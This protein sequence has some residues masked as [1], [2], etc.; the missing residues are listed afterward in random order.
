MSALVKFIV[1]I[2]VSLLFFSCQWDINLG[3]GERGNGNVV[4]EAR[5]SDESF[6][7][8]K[9]AEGLD[10]YITQDKKTSI[11][12][13]ADENIIGLIRTDIKNGILR[14]HTEERI[15]RAK[16]KKVFVS[17]PEI[18][19]LRSSSGADLYTTAVIKAD[20]IE[21]DSSSG[22]D[23]KV[24][25]EANEVDCD[26]SSGSDIVVSGKAKILYADAST[27]SDIKAR[28]LL[29]TKCIAKASTGAD[30]SV[31]ATDELVANTSTGGDVNYTGDPIVKKS[32]STAGT[33]SKN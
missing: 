12:V 5:N 4:T 7:V 29:V 23:L 2:F 31:N 32:K 21:L 33:V 13:E 11:S 3:E 30:I 14:I 1:M 9:A 6:T 18:T 15:G 10:V 28:K 20:R 19:S 17:L 27:G 26:A 16:S 25:V 22:A 8:V 24:E